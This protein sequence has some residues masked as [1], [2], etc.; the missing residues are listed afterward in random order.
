MPDIVNNGSQG[1]I[2]LRRSIWAEPGLQEG[3]GL[4]TTVD[5][6]AG[7]LKC[8]ARRFGEYLETLGRTPVGRSRT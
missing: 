3:R 2:G 8:Q 7:V 6:E 1:R 4:L 5:E